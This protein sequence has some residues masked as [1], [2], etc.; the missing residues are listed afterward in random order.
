MP[1]MIYRAGRSLKR[2]GRSADCCWVTG[3]TLTG[4]LSN[5]SLSRF[6][7]KMSARRVPHC[8]IDKKCKKKKREKK[9][10]EGKIGWTYGEVL[11][12]VLGLDIDVELA[13]LGVLGEVEGGD[14]GDV[15][16]LALT[17]LL[18]ELEGDT[19]DG[20]SLDTLDQV[21]GVAGNLQDYHR[22]SKLARLF[23]LFFF[24]FFL[25]KHKSSSCGVFF[26]SCCCCCC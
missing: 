6:T 22:K 5:C 19:A 17:L 1:V 23:F 9:G 26:C 7:Q 2:R 18:L 12:Q 10:K 15:L 8:V 16:I 4:T 11:Q 13:A 21:G 25:F 3:T 20:S 24:F 14:L